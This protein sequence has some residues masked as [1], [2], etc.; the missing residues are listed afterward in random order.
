MYQYIQNLNGNWQINIFS[1]NDDEPDEISQKIEICG[2]NCG[3]DFFDMAYFTSI[4]CSLLN[5]LKPHMGYFV[6]PLFFRN[7]PASIDTQERLSMTAYCP[8]DPRDV[9]VC[10]D[11]F[12]R[13]RTARLIR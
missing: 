11:A 10:M 2:W 5:R 3:N 8:K 12:I 6:A 7:I 9:D 13:L 4:T 1:E